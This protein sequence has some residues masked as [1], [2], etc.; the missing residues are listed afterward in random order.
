MEED[1]DGAEKEDQQPPG[2]RL[3]PDEVTHGSHFPSERVAELEALS[4]QPGV[5]NQ[6]ICALAPSIWEMD[7]IKKGVLCMLFGGNNRKVK[8]GTSGR[9]RNQQRVRQEM[10]DRDVDVEEPELDE[11]EEG[12][13]GY[14]SKLNK[15][16]NINI[17]LM[18]DLGT[19]KC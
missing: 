2:K 11:E 17:L 13:E 3:R 12:E 14:N 8:K 7:G 5:Y 16:G 19:S 9:K 18:G 15:Q 6:L 4:K 1:E 10:M